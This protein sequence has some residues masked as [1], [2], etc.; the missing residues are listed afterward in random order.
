MARGE[1]PKITWGAGFVNTLTLGYPLQN[2][3]AYSEPR[4]G[5]EFTMGPS[6]E[7]DSWITGTNQYL[8]GGAAWIP[9]ADGGGV[10]GWDGATGFRAFLESARAK[11]DFKFFPDKDG[12]G[13]V[14]CRLAEPMAGAPALE[15]D[16]TR[17]VLLKIRSTDDSAF[18]GY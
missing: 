7:E 13:N 14:T 1:T 3:V 10:T 2:A 8:E 15:Q 5:S 16:L 17:R 18:T 11:N 9:A 6:G 4:E 12:G